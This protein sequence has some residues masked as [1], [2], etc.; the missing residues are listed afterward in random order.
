MDVCAPVTCV[1]HETWIVHT[2]SIVTL[3]Q[4]EPMK[5]QL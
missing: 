5:R 1:N 3:K 4:Q 2:V